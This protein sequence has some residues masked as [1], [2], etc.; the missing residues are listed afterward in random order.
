M[1]AGPAVPHAVPKGR[2]GVIP[3]GGR[4]AMRARVTILPSTERTPMPDEPDTQPL[5]DDGEAAAA[6]RA[7]AAAGRAGAAARG[8]A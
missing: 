2:L 5:P 1:R 7:A 6:D 4:A 3:D 8:R